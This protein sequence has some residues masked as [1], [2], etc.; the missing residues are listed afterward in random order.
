M[1]SR[2]VFPL[3]NATMQRGDLKFIPYYSI[4]V[5]TVFPNVRTDIISVFV[6]HLIEDCI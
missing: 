1:R 5:A 3:E 6:S 4:K 2:F